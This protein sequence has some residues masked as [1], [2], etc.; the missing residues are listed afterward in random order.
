MN[1]VF[2]NGEMVKA[3][4]ARISIFDRGFLYADGVFETIRVQAG[5]AFRWDRHLSRLQ[6]GLRLLG[7]G[8][9]YEDGVLSGHAE[10]LIATNRCM[11]GVLRVTVSRGPGRRGLSPAGADSPTIAM[12][13]HPA[14]EREKNAGLRLISSEIRVLAGDPLAAVKSASKLPYVLARAAADAAGV[15]D[16]LILNH[17]N[18][19]A[20]TTSSNLF[21]LK[22]AVL[23]TPACSV[24]VL[25]GVAREAVLGL[26]GTLGCRAEE[27]AT[28]RRAVLEADGIFTTNVVSGVTEVIEVDGR[29]LKRSGLV[30]KFREAFEEQ[31]QAELA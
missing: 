11:Q 30:R 21:W 28:E 7:M 4:E 18:E 19:I 5:K 15:D 2:L 8:L 6:N 3:S 14:P 25:P 12:S 29:A 16:A 1:I 31:V 9:P 27:V 10:K 24:G 26:A 20:E 17:R 13:L 22:G 23:F